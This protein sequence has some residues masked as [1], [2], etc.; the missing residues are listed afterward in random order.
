M[1]LKFASLSAVLVSC[2]LLLLGVNAPKA[3]AQAAKASQATKGASTKKPNIILIVSDDFGHGDDG[4]YGG[5]EGR[6]MPT[7][8]L[9]KF[10]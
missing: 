2:L 10:R 1:Q 6:G 5:G 8:A 9:D 7:P 3:T 4:V